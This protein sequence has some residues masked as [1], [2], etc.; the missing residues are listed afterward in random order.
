MRNLLTNEPD[1]Y[2]H[3]DEIASIAPTKHQARSTKTKTERKTKEKQK[4][5]TKTR[6]T[7]PSHPIQ[8][9]ASNEPANPHP[10]K[11]YINKTQ[12]EN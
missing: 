11:A 6:N 2:R 12:T 10:T 9:P 5:K 7:P 3:C 4:R 1:P 8:E